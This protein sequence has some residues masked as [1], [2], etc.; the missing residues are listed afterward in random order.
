MKTASYGGARHV[1]LL[2]PEKTFRPT[3]NSQVTLTDFGIAT[4]MLTHRLT[5]SHFSDAVGTPAYMSPEQVRADRTPG[6]YP[7]KISIPSN[8]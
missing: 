5:L 3:S 2:S 4:R 6:R 8:A 7:L 1:L